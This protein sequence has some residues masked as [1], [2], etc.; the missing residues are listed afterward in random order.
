MGGL[1]GVSIGGVFFGE[2][3]FSFVSNSSKFALF[4]LI[5]RLKMENFDFIDTQFINKHLEQFGALEIPNGNFKRILSKGIK[6]IEIFLNFML[7]VF[8]NSLLPLNSGII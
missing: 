1:Y 3:M 6:K 8:P 5:E 7:R 4:H 2:S